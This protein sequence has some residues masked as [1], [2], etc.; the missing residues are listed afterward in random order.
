MLH[1]AWNSKE[2]MPYCFPR[3][4]IKFQGHTGQNIT[5][6]DPNCF[7]TIGRSQLSNPSDLP[8][9]LSGV[10]AKSCKTNIQR[11][12]TINI[13]VR[14]ELWDLSSK[15]CVSYKTVLSRYSLQFQWTTDIIQRCCKAGFLM[16]HLSHFQHM[17]SMPE[18][19]RGQMNA[20]C[21]FRKVL[22]VPRVPWI[23][24]WCSCSSIIYLYFGPRSCHGQE[25]GLSNWHSMKRILCLTSK[26]PQLTIAS[27]V[28]L[29]FLLNL[30]QFWFPSPTSL[31]R[32]RETITGS[33]GWNFFHQCSAD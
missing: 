28:I 22:V 18:S 4:S 27:F 7:R 13:S 21:I 11:E 3:S 9:F 1:K 10:G 2:E 15:K 12:T 6:C 31:C 24:W 29:A 17:C 14:I 33:S 5:D 16:A 20:N 26:C 25:S 8:C 23:L 30:F 19:M 32:G